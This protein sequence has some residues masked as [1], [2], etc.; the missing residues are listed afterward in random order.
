M[1]KTIGMILIL[2]CSV[3][4]GKALSGRAASFLKTNEALLAFVMYIST[5]IKTARIPIPTI[6]DTFTNDELEDIGFCKAIREN[7]LYSA[8]A[9]I[10]NNVS[11]E[12]YD[13]MMYLCKNL[14][15]IDAKSQEDICSYTEARLRDEISRIKKDMNDKKKMYRLLPILAGL[16]AIILLI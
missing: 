9:D 3:L 4:Y 8:L 5:S 11:K 13:A 15:G 7:G 10:R 16:S 2:I 1:L 12:S 6:Y 14:G